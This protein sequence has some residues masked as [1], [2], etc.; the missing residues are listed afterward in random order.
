MC[1]LNETESLEMGVFQRAFPGLKTGK[2]QAISQNHSYF[3]PLPKKPVNGWG[4]ERR[5]GESDWVVVR[6]F[7]EKITGSYNTKQGHFKLSLVNC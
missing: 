2:V 6:T 5:G 4:R 7:F 3:L 1:T